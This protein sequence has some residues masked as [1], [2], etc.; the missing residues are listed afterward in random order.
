M[1]AET[2]HSLVIRY[3]G[4]DVLRTISIERDIEN[5]TSIDIFTRWDDGEMVRTR[6][7]LTHDGFELLAKAVQEF[8]QNTDS[9]KINKDK[10][11]NNEV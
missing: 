5:T 2:T 1:N 3:E 9:Y 4:P 7:Y 8:E 11:N 10:E 6:T